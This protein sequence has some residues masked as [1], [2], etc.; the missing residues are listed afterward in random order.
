MKKTA[1]LLI[2][3]ISLRFN[4][5]ASWTSATI[6]GFDNQTGL[7]FFGLNADDDDNSGYYVNIC[8]YDAK[9]DKTAYVF[10]AESNDRIT[11]FYYQ[12]G[13]S[14]DL[15]R[16]LLNTDDGLYSG[17]DK[18]LKIDYKKASLNL[19]VITYSEKQES[20]SLW[21]CGKNGSGLKKLASYGSNTELKIDVYYNKVLLIR[22]EKNLLKIESFQY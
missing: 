20:Y 8:V 1:C 6:E 4:A 21:I 16:I 5:S 12:T 9:N 19:I 18:T 2:L 10:P 7:Y 14:A 11:G 22:Q 13:Y 17:S 3:L 15:N